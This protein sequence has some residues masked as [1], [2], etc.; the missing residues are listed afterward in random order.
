MFE[1]F[2]AL[3]EMYA[4]RDQNLSGGRK[5]ATCDRYLQLNCVWIAG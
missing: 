1:L 5:I 3:V 2:V 4:E